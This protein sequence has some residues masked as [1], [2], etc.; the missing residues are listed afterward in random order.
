MDRMSSLQKFFF[1]LAIAI[2]LVFVLAPYLWMVSSSFKSTLEIQSMRPTWIP[3]TFTFQNYVEMNRIV[4]IMRYFKNSL[5]IS[6]GAMILTIIIGVLAAYGISRFNFK[7]RT[8]YTMLLFS[9]QMLPGVMFLIPYF[10]IFNVIRNTFGIPMVDT[11]HGLILTYTQFALPFSILMLRN[12]LDSVPRDI[13]EQAMI[14]GCNRAGA[15]FRVILPLA[16]PG[17]AAMGIYAFIMGWNEILFATVLTSTKTR[18]IALGLL[19][20]ITK[21]TAAWGSMMAACIITS[22]PIFVL[23]TLGQKHIVSGL[24][25]GATKG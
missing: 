10:V 9:T 19:N 20:Y 15:L 25:S 6:G 7:G 13:D 4:P 3:Q 24:V 8:F 17:I 5:I 14:D 2:I 21:H 12:Y 22:I 18:T 16:K 23:F 11:Y 1:A